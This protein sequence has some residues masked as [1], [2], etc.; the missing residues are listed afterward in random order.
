MNV[1]EFMQ[2]ANVVLYMAV[3]VAFLIAL[4]CLRVFLYKRIKQS[5]F[6]QENYHF[7]TLDKKIN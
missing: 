3:G 7:V 4:L 2:G 5:S 6:L 1:R